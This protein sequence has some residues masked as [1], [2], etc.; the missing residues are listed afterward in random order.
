MLGDLAYYCVWVLEGDAD[1]SKRWSGVAGIWCNKVADKNPHDGRP[2][3]HLG[4]IAKPRILQ[5]LFHYSKAL[6]SVSPFPN[7]W[8]SLMKLFELFPK[9]S[10]LTS[11][12]YSLV[13]STLIK[14]HSALFKLRSIPEYKSLITQFY[15]GLHN[16][17]DR[18][19]EKFS[20]QSSEIA[21]ILCTAAC[22][23]GESP[24]YGDQKFHDDVIHHARQ[25]L[26][27]TVFAVYTDGEEV[28]PFI[29][30]ILVYL[31]SSAFAP[32]TVSHAERYIP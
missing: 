9:G 7:T 23:F 20:E 13:E 16:H 17:T 26:D 30:I 28:L 18:L 10:E 14:A 32:G 31:Y 3:H 5:Q 12:K 11:Q 29:H 22:D 15:L 2:Q 8:P 27:K 19:R 24:T 25:V 21:F 1:A 4:V 6:V